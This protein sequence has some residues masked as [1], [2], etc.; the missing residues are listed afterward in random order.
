SLARKAHYLFTVRR[1]VIPTSVASGQSPSGRSSG[2]G[3]SGSS[4]G[5]GPIRRCRLTTNSLPQVTESNSRVDEE[6]LDKELWIL[7]KDND[8]PSERKVFI[9]CH[10]SVKHK[11]KLL[12][13][14]QENVYKMAREI[15]RSLQDCLLLINICS[16]LLASNVGLL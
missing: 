8:V 13:T 2:G 12:N 14:P 9:M 16:G 5:G 3:P 1:I 10:M 4:G 7:L 11:K 6:D 15:E